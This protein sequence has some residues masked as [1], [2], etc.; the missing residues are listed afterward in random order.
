MNVNIKKAFSAGLTQL[1]MLYDRFPALP[2]SNQAFSR[3]SWEDVILP[4]PNLIG[5]L[6]M[7]DPARTSVAHSRDTHTH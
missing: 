6:W 1:Q 4:P 3:E 2:P 7:G 5:C